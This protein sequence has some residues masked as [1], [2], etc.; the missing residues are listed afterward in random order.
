M[1]DST[2][3][4]A[5]GA[6]P[7]TSG[8]PS[9]NQAAEGWVRRMQTGLTL[10]EEMELADWLAADPQHEICLRKYQA[11]WD[12]FAPLVDTIAPD[13]RFEPD[14]AARPGRRSRRLR[15]IIPALGMAA[16]ITLLLLFVSRERA[17]SVTPTAPFQLPAL[18]E[19]RTLPDGS[20]VEL[21]RGARITVHFT[22]AERGV[23]LD[24]GEA[25]FTVAKNPLR[26]FVVTAGAVGVRAVGTEFN[27]RFD[28]RMVEVLVTEGK[29]RIENGAANT[30]G[31]EEST[32]LTA[33][34]KMSFGGN[35]SSP[36]PQVATL[37]PA[38]VDAHLAWRPKLLDFDDAPLSAIIAE[39]NRR[40]SVRLVITD[41]VIADRRMTATF[42]S[43]NLEGF[44]RL[45][46]A[47][48][49][50]RALQSGENEIALVPK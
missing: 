45:L 39:F 4:P 7:G 47:N 36:P 33:G 21:N 34:Q 24:Q 16:S 43:D 14:P 18:C 5:T 15:W 38:Q 50:V 30:A 31:G 41:S 28:P 29:V 44:V 20:V 3:R 2:R 1:R 13:S 17:P 25:T 46:E 42:R 32:T 35:P 48:I 23:T 12:R 6:L 27:V 40:N 49:G 9:A 10:E 19:Q 37:T 26:P 22:E 8:A 11:A